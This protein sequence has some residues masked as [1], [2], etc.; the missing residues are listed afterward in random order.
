MDVL[1][2]VDILQDDKFLYTGDVWGVVVGGGSGVGVWLEGCGSEGRSMAGLGG[3]WWGGGWGDAIANSHSGNRH[4]GNKIALG[5]GIKIRRRSNLSKQWSSQ[6]V[7][8]HLSVYHH[9]WDIS[10]HFSSV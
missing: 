8:I 9:F 10:L 1:A 2:A 3:W 6:A 7:W 4:E 5:I